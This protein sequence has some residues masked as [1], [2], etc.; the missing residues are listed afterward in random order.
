MEEDTVSTISSV[1]VTAFDRSA[2]ETRPRE[3]KGDTESIARDAEV[4]AAPQGTTD[5]IT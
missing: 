2:V 5:A 4:Y 3:L 1:I